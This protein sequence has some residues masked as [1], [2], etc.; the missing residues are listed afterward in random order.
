MTDKVLEQY[1]AFLQKTERSLEDHSQRIEETLARLAVG[2]AK[3]SDVDLEDERS[4]P[5]QR[6]H[7]LD[8]TNTPIESRAEHNSC[9]EPQRAG[10]PAI[11]RQHKAS[12]DLIELADGAQERLNA[13][14][15][16]IYALEKV[17]LEKDLETSR[18]QLKLCKQ[19]SDKIDDTTDPIKVVEE[20]VV[21]SP[22]V[23]EV[24]GVY[25]TGGTVQVFGPMQ[26]ELLRQLSADHSTINDQFQSRDGFSITAHRN[27]QRRL[28]YVTKRAQPGSGLSE[29][30]E[31][32]SRMVE[33]QNTKAMTAEEFGDGN[34]S[35]AS[36]LLSDS[37][38]LWE[39]GSWGE[40]S[41]T[42]GAPPEI[43]KL[44]MQEISGSVLDDTELARIL[45][46]SASHPILK[47]EIVLAEFKR[48]LGC[49]YRDLGSSSNASEFKPVFQLLKRS[50]G[51]IVNRSR[52]L[53]GLV[54]GNLLS[55]V[56][57][58][59]MSQRAKL[60]MIYLWQLTLGIPTK[61]NAPPPR[62]TD[63]TDTL[64]H[65]H[66]RSDNDDD[67]SVEEGAYPEISAA[68]AFLKD[69]VPMQKFQVEMRRFIMNAAWQHDVLGASKSWSLSL[70]KFIDD[71]WNAFRPILPEPRIPRGKRRIRWTCVS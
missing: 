53:L 27:H 14:T 34:D 65:P 21:E 60:E 58:A 56:P 26:D 67:S 1:K 7:V 28:P 49:Y 69:G 19:A 6:L 42:S 10:S 11:D 29:S 40:S 41:A 68:I 70:L 48:L 55:Q 25:T 44:S 39:C 2:A 43:M 24:R 38:S 52:K 3:A 12:D 33:N 61:Q 13:L 4:T 59:K 47:P 36:E 18:H 71:L 17:H 5:D 62:Q 63:Y 54:H 50:R 16:N 8:E 31:N 20:L 64:D 46:A 57:G 37:S 9:F 51:V 45:E 66:E 32:S 35:A 15:L 22:S 30:G 23:F